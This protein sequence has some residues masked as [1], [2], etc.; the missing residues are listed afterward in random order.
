MGK[1][2]YFYF[3]SLC[4]AFTLGESLSKL[5]IFSDPNAK[6]LCID[7]SKNMASYLDVKENCIQVNFQFEINLILHT[8]L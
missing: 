6:I 4:H 1:K 7:F 8:D 3:V 2:S 5:L